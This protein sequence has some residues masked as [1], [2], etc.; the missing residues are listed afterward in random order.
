MAGSRAVTSLL[1]VSLGLA[2]CMSTADVARSVLASL[3]PE[4]ALR[5]DPVQDETLQEPPAEPPHPE[6][7]TVMWNPDVEEPKFDWIRLKSDEWLKGELGMLQD[8]KLEFDSDE[9]GDLKLDWDDVKE[10]HTSVSCTVLLDDYS[11]VMGPLDMIDREFVVQT[12]EGPQVFGRARVRA[13]IP[14]EPREGNYWSGRFT[15]GGSWRSGNTDQVLLDTIFHVQ[16]RT[17]RSRAQVDYNGAYGKI[18]GEENVNNQ[19]LGGFYDYFF[20]ERLYMR[21]FALDLFRDPFQNI[22]LRATP[23]VGAGYDL[24]ESGKMDWDITGGVGYQY[25]MSDSTAAG[26]DSERTFGALL[27]GTVFDWD[28]TADVEFRFTYNLQL[29]A[30]SGT[31]T[32]HYVLTELSVDLLGPLDLDLALTW[33][34]T[35]D[36]PPDSN[37]VTPEK[38]DVRLTVGLGIDF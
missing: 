25:E 6:Q 30:D 8:G 36:P 15:F 26:D 24:L 21:A 7:P 32:N 28:V 34:R 33:W 35:G 22:A 29:L 3:D 38:D 2:S 19:K 9:L 4:A 11:T 12:A 23:S 27:A 18:E 13:I 16:R 31:S 5:D 17:V 37:G 20:T 10:L 14:G 1:V